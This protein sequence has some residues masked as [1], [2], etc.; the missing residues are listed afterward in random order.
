MAWGR[1]KAVDSAVF[2]GTDANGRPFAPRDPFIYFNWLFYD[3]T[4]ARHAHINRHNRAINWVIIKKQ[5]Y[6]AHSEEQVPMSLE[7]CINQRLSS[8]RRQSNEITR[9]YL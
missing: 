6:W 3:S 4:I 5:V 7:R 8:F 1:G 2:Q 9:D